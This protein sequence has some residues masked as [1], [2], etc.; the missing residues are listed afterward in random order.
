MSL[1]AVLRNEAPVEEIARWVTVLPAMEEANVPEMKIRLKFM[2]QDTLNTIMK[3]IKNKRDEDINDKDE[4]RFRKIFAKYTFDD[5]SGVTFENLQRCSAW[6]MQ[7][8][9]TFKKD[10]PDE[11]IEFSVDDAMWLAE[12]MDNVV[13][14]NRILAEALSLDKYSAMQIEQEKKD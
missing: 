1:L 4:A 9:A 13:W 6:F 8:A 5:W 12:K 14:N 3:P 10:I 2:A 11:G 7:R